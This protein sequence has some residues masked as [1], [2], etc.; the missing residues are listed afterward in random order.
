MLLRVLLHTFAPD[1]PLIIG[2]DETLEWRR[3]EKIRTK[4]IYRDA[5]RSSHA[6]FVKASGLRW[7]CA[8]LLVDLSW[9]GLVWG[10]ARADG[11]LPVGTLPLI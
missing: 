1:G 3:G 8:R 11:T 9:A 2:L 7:L 6:Y 5:V 10:T 4:G